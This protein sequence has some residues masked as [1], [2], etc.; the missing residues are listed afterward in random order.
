MTTR[1]L[2]QINTSTE[3]GK[4]EISDCQFIAS[5][6][7]VEGLQKTI[8]VPG[9][10]PIWTPLAGATVLR[11]DSG[12]YYRDEN[13]ARFPE[14]SMEPAVESIFMM[15]TSFDPSEVDVFG[16][17][18]TF[19]DILRFAMGSPQPFSFTAHM[20]GKTVFFLRRNH[21]PTE[22][23]DNV[24]GYGHAFPEAYTTWSQDVK[25]S[26]SHQ[27]IIKYSFGGL[28][29]L[30]R[31]E[32]DGYI[33]DQADDSEDEDH[34]HMPGKAEV[35][36]SSEISTDALVEKFSEDTFKPKPPL[37]EHSGESLVVRA[38]GRPTPQSSLF[39][40][41]TRSSRKQRDEIMAE[42][43]P[44]L[45]VRVRFT[46]SSWHSIRAATLILRTFWT[47]RTRCTTGSR[48]RRQH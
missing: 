24:H 36:K 37:V 18:S 46:S 29:C 32:A 34:A 8:F 41:K 1:T 11:P 17:G 45:W 10:P 9:R 38:Q 30:V 28:Q 20:I 5:Y 12:D 3:S 15:N 19:G 39:D 13:A 42:Q 48:N 21:S 35:A 22:L 2:D 27:R 44:R 40:L 43:L 33:L 14:Y 16:C 23:I 4:A 7:L 6:N 26:A 47:S 25:G 31:F